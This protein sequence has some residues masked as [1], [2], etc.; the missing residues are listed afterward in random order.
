VIAPT[1]ANMT[2]IRKLPA[3]MRMLQDY[4][5]RRRIPARVVGLGFRPEDVRSPER[6]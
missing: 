3:L 4:P 2:P 6:P 1:L 5:Y